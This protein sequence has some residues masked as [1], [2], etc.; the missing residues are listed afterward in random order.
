MP[1]WMGYGSWRPEDNR[2]GWSSLLG[3]PAGS[4]SVPYGSVPARIKNLT[5]LPPTFI[6]V[7]SVDLFAEEDVEYARRLIRAGVATELLVIPGAYHVFHL[8]HPEPELS[9]QFS[10]SIDRAVHRAFS[11]R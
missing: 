10:D 8:M 4:E 2:L 3:V 9:I 5:G 1:Y 6:A 11:A 7:G